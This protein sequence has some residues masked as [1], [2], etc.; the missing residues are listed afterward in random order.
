VALSPPRFAIDHALVHDDGREHNARA[1]STVKGVQMSMCSSRCDVA[2][3]RASKPISIG[4]LGM[5]NMYCLLSKAAFLVLSL[6]LIKRLRFGCHATRTNKIVM[7]IAQH[8]SLLATAVAFE[9][10]APTMIGNIA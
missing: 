10:I 3:T 6:R 7:M 5:I 4:L 2:S 1:A 8:V 9:V